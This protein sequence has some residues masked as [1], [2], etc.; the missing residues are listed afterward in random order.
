MSLKIGREINDRLMALFAQLQRL[1]DVA[2]QLEV[3][4]ALAAQDRYRGWKNAPLHVE[5]YSARRLQRE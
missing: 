5:S 1:E 3:D 2:H 4:D